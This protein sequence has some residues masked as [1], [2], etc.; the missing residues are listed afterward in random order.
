MALTK[1]P[2]SKDPFLRQGDRE[3]HCECIRNSRKARPAFTA[4]GGEYR[5][6]GR[7]FSGRSMLRPYGTVGPQNTSG[8]CRSCGLW[9]QRVGET[10]VHRVWWRVQIAWA[11]LQRAQ[12]AAPL[13]IRGT[14]ERVRANLSRLNFFD[15]TSRR[16]QRSPRLVAST[17]CLGSASAGAACCAPT[18]PCYCGT[19]TDHVV[20][21]SFVEATK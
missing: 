14:A 5:L 21:L 18:E 2:T 9:M 13:R 4:F 15:A 19:R 17:D 11:A 20:P 1:G 8:S 7:R 3:L 10:S 6:P 16:D 12:H